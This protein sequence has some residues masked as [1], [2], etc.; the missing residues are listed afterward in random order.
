METWLIWQLT[1]AHVTDYANAS[2]TMLFD[3]H[4]PAVG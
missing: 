4:A 3:I 1:G 2:R